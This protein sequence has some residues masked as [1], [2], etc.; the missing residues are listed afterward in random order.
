M[1]K[2]SSIRREHEL[3][4][5]RRSRHIKTLIEEAILNVLAE[6]EVPVQPPMS[7]PMPPPVA[8]PENQAQVNAEAPQQYSVDD[9]IE[10]LNVIR[11]GRSFSDPEVYGK[12]VTFFKNTSDEQRTVLES[13][14]AQIADLVTGVDEDDAN[15][16]GN[17]QGQGQNQG[18]PQGAPQ[19]NAP[20][21]GAQTAVGAAGVGAA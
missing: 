12:L 2:K 5:E 19:Q 13:L 15:D 16:E 3:V 11:G 8:T 17:Q 10:A 4:K 6:Q 18:S 7:D 21:P 14:L 9:L 1:N 20:M